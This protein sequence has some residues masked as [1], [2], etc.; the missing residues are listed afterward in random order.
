LRKNLDAASSSPA[1]SAKVAPAPAGSPFKAANQSV[2]AVPAR[3]IYNPPEFESALPAMAASAEVEDGPIAAPVPEAR[4]NVLAEA[5]SS[6]KTTLHASMSEPAKPVASPVAPA[7]FKSPVSS[8]ASATGAAAAPAPAKETLVPA[9]KKPA[10]APSVEHA[11]VSVP[12]FGAVIPGS[13]P[14][15][16]ALEADDSGSSGGSRKVLIAAAVVLVV[17]ALAYFG[18]TKLGKTIPGSQRISAPAVS[19]APRSVTPVAPSATASEPAGSAGQAVVLQNAKPSASISSSSAIVIGADTEPVTKKTGPAAIVVK[20][21][22]AGKKTQ[23]R[24]EEP[25]PQVPSPLAVA[26]P[27]DKDL[28]G[29]VSS[30]PSALPTAVLATLKISQGVSQGL[31]IKRVQPRYPQTAL[32]MRIQGAVQMEAT[33]NKEGN[34]SNLKVVSGDAVLARAAAEAVRQWRYKPYYLN[35]EPVEIETQITVN[36]RLPN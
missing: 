5:D 31:L 33:I 16:A 18:W 30:V 32:A 13:S 34:I 25:A 26:S 20:S 19:P 35:G 4:T 3:S 11:E 9:E 28:S 22:T 27:N 12:T 36:F 17:A 23:A 10:I 29:L 2:D 14:S 1:A 8:H 6:P 21:Y 7:P 24:V 15:F